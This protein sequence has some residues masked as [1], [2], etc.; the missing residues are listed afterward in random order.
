MESSDFQ[1]PDRGATLQSIRRHKWHL[2][3][4][5]EKLAKSYTVIERA[6]NAISESTTL[7][8]QID[9]EGK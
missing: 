2:E 3:L 1:E 9:S 5:H 8:E 6:E 7:L 4:I